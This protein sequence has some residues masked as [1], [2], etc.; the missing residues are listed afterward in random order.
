V[1][2]VTQN[3]NISKVGERG[4][5]KSASISITNNSE[6]TN[7][8][9]YKKLNIERVSSNNVNNRNDNSKPIYQNNYINSNNNSNNNNTGDNNN[10]NQINQ[11]TT[12]INYKHIRTNS[13]IDGTSIG[14]ISKN[15]E[16][17]QDNYGKDKH[18]RDS[19]S[20][21]VYEV[22]NTE[23]VNDFH[24]KIK[25]KRE[26]NQIL[27][28]N[29]NNAPLLTEVF[30]SSYKNK[31]KDNGYSNGILNTEPSK[32]ENNTK[33]NAKYSDNQTELYIKKVNNYKPEIK[34][35]ILNL[36]GNGI[37]NANPKKTNFFNTSMSFD[38]NVD[39]KNTT[40]E[41]ITNNTVNKDIK[42]KL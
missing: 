27:F 22:L 38:Q 34:K 7:S 3:I 2:I 26:K 33:F 32:P 11:R 40:S 10:N 37:G 15:K 31:E 5:T 21:K 13:L 29:S 18:N 28:N 17:D 42:K 30:N 9:F 4:H 39:V 16:N 12:P 14:M 6:S 41:N 25:D 35:E 1:S 8:S 36:N 23:Y 24:N 19:K 20:N